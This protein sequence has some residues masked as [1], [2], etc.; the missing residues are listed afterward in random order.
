[1]LLLS[2]L[3]YNGDTTETAA[4][5]S[6]S[7]KQGVWL[8]LDWSVLLFILRLFISWFSSQCFLLLSL[9]P[10]GNSVEISRFTQM[11][12][13]C[14]ETIM[15]FSDHPSWPCFVCYALLPVVHD[16]QSFCTVT[17][18]HSSWSC[19]LLEAFVS[20]LA[21]MARL[22]LIPLAPVLQHFMTVITITF[23]IFIW[24][25]IPTSCNAEMG[26]KWSQ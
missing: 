25:G 21:N 14:K 17:E 13:S 11:S 18:S 12:K 8:L 3:V 22:I 24:C 6:Q 4:T 7:R 2:L 10:I 15:H 20:L 26:W 9:V 23:F 16:L 1:M 19:D 5:L